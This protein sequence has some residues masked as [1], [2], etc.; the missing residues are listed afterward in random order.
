MKKSQYALTTF[1][2]DHVHGMNRIKLFENKNALG[3]KKFFGVTITWKH[4]FVNW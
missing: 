1:Q 3:G 4:F 2:R